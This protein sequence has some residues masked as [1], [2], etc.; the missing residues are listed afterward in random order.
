M[1]ARPPAL[2]IIG[3]VV[4]LRAKLAKRPPQAGLPAAVGRLMHI[5]P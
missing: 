1:D 3:E 4:R 2:L 5:K